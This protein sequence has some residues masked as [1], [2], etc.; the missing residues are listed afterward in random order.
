MMARHELWILITFACVSGLLLGL[1]YLVE[2]IAESVRLAI[3]IGWAAV[4]I[5][6]WLPLLDRL[7][8][9]MKS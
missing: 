9:R 1:A 4:C 7:S 6:S 2:D 3:A 5:S 8:R